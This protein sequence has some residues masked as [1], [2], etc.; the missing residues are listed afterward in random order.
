MTWLDVGGDE[1]LVAFAL[2]SGCAA[3]IDGTADVTVADL[4][5]VLTAWGPCVGP[6][7]ADIDASGTVD[8]VDVLSVL[9]AWGPCF[10]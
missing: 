8:F 3:D 2:A 10:P 6:C 5:A 4:L 1:H 9:S 7:P